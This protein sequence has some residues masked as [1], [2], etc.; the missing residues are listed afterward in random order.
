MSYS[1]YDRIKEQIKDAIDIVQLVSRFVPLKRAGRNYVGRC[2][3]HDDSRP[4]LQVNPERQSY[5]CWVCNVGGDIFS[6]IMQME[7][8]DFKEALEILAEMTGISLKDVKRQNRAGRV[9]ERK[10]ND[11]NALLDETGEEEGESVAAP[12]PIDRRTLFNTMD[13]VQKQYHE[14]LLSMDEAENARKYLSERGINEQSVRDFRI[15]Y[16]PLDGSWLMNK[17]GGASRRIECL[18]TAGVLARYR[19]EE[20]NTERIYDR[21][22][23]RLMFPIRDTQDRTVAF[24]G[25]I[26]PDSPL[27]SSAK[28]VNSPETPIFSKSKQL[29]GLDVARLTMRTTKRALIME[30]YTDTIMAHQCGIGDAVAILGTALGPDHIKILERFVEKMILVLDGDTAGRKRANEVL[31][32]FVAQGVDLTIATLPAGADPCEFLQEQGKERFEELLREQGIDGLEH[33]F[34]TATLGVNIEKDIVGSSRALDQ[35]IA[36]IASAPTSLRGADDPVQLRL[37]KTI[38]RLAERFRVSETEIRKRLKQWKERKSQTKN[39]GGVVT[40]EAVEETS[41]WNRPELTPDALEREM[42]ELWFA[43]PTTFETLDNVIPDEWIRSPLTQRVQSL[44]REIQ[45]EERECSFSKILVHFDDPAVKSLL[46]ELDESAGDKGL[47]PKMDEDRKQQL[48]TE[49]VQGF[50]RRDIKRRNPGE[51]SDLKNETLSKEEKR[52]K[53]QESLDRA[54]NR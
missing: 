37:E 8:V 54:R 27:K 45:T 32:L 19:D 39:Y 31:E 42:L 25:R 12:Q 40:E 43:D 10:T 21:F 5:R 35:M 28:Y 9:S 49:I 1:D 38:A 16:S 2:P 14:A 15:G 34:R 50:T 22:R 47:D 7:K 30:G 23:G 18:E 13:W 52:T 48:I 26:L 41:S 6:F 11:P 24:G 29:Y 20:R 17:V 46:V 44:W 4:S 53:V 33:A 3:W 36:L 51:L